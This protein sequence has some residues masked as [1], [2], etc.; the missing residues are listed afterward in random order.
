MKTLITC[1]LATLFLLSIAY[2]ADIKG[3]VTNAETGSA[4]PGAN[5]TITTTFLGASSDLEGYFNIAH[6]KSTLL[7]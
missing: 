2:S 7:E 3:V 5:V 1:I 6:L 4:L